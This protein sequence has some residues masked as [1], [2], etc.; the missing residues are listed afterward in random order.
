MGV[1]RHLLRRAV[2]EVDVSDVSDVPFVFLKSLLGEDNV[3]EG[4]R[5]D[6]DEGDGDVSPLRSLA[7]ASI[8]TSCVSDLSFD[9]FFASLLLLGEFG[10][11]S[12]SWPTL[13]TLFEPRDTISS[14]SSLTL[15]R[16]TFASVGGSFLLEL[17]ASLT[18][19]TLN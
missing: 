15:L 4:L 9:R 6:K 11:V 14:G 16:L 3:E 17:V 12:L 7:A 13:V 18:S 5:A 19:V 8:S 10:T 1:D 2:T